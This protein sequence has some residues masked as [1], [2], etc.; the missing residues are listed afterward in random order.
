MSQYYY[1]L[2]SRPNKPKMKPV[3]NNKQ[4]IPVQ[5]VKESTSAVVANEKPMVCAVEESTSQPALPKVDISEVVDVLNTSGES[6]VAE[7]MAVAE[8]IEDT[9][10]KKRRNKKKSEE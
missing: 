9:P 3:K 1:I 6:A 4:S 5:F 2:N 10:K 7:A 8:G